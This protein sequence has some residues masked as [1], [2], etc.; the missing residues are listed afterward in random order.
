MTEA[1]KMWDAFIKHLNEVQP[2]KGALDK[3]TGKHQLVKHQVFLGSIASYK[4]I[5]MEA[6]I[7]DTGR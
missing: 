3:K 7:V 6:N 1:E 2:I 5:F 4:K